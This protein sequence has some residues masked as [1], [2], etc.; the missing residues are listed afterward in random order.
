MIAFKALLAGATGAA[1]AADSVTAQGLASGS[2]TVWRDDADAV[3]ASQ[4][5]VAAASLQDCLTAC[6]ISNDCAGVAM[7][8]D[9]GTDV[10]AA[11]SSCNLIRGDSTVGTF[12]RSMTRVVTSRLTTAIIGACLVVCVGGRRVCGV[13][14]SQSF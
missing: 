6:D 12:K 1:S 13:L 9:G 14:K 4:T 11:L 10:T 3:G 2:Y 7:M 8:T 5:P